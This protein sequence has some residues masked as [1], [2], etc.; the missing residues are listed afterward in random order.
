[1]TNYKVLER[2]SRLTLEYSLGLWKRTRKARRTFALQLYRPS[3][4]LLHPNHLRYW[5][6]RPILMPPCQYG[7][8]LIHRHNS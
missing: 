7:V 8:T 2:A 1:V 4:H 5:C 3:W 6:C